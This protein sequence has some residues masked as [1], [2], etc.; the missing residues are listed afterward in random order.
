MRLSIVCCGRS[1]GETPQ[2]R[3]RPV[4]SPANITHAA[5]RTE[6]A[7][8]PEDS[9]GCLKIYTW[10]T[11]RDE[12]SSSILCWINARRRCGRRC[13]GAI[14]TQCSRSEKLRSGRETLSTCVRQRRPVRAR[15]FLNSY[16]M[17]QGEGRVL[18]SRPDRQ[19]LSYSSKT[20]DDFAFYTVDV[21]LGVMSKEQP[22]VRKSTLHSAFMAASAC[23]RREGD[24]W[25]TISSCGHTR[26]LGAT[27]WSTYRSAESSAT[28]V[29][30]RRSSRL[31]STNI[32]W[33]CWFPSA[34]S[35]TE[36]LENL[37]SLGPDLEY[38]WDGE[39]LSG[40]DNLHVSV[41]SWLC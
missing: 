20:D 8:V 36:R 26:R 31:T 38:F 35:T 41:T 24:R 21:L 18:A 11:A 29:S 28:A 2:A 37:D 30:G 1:D 40:V 22:G 16:S 32:G 25:M 27:L 5:G 33:L 13:L 23:A 6:L 34:G 19:I 10:S 15:P 39:V 9:G 3:D 17:R 4:S 14:R 7:G 12:C